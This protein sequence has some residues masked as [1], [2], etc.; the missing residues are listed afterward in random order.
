MQNL[1]YIMK[2]IDYGNRLKYLNLN[3]LCNIFF[4]VSFKKSFQK[5]LKIFLCWNLS[6]S[7]FLICS[8]L[9]TKSGW[10][11]YEPFTVLFSYSVRSFVLLTAKIT[12]VSIIFQIFDIKLQDLW[13]LKFFF[14]IHIPGKIYN[15]LIGHTMYFYRKIKYSFFMLPL[16]KKQR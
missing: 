5:V 9:F 11:S 14:M 16:Q 12:K 8:F 1:A 10:C 13:I 15:Y 2:L 6:L 7:M 4:I 3:T